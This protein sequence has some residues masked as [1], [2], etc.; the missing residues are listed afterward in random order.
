[1]H[2]SYRFQNDWFSSTIEEWTETL[3]EYRSTP[4]L[5]F[6]E[7]G[8]FEGRSAVWLLENILTNPTSVLTCI[9]T[10]QGSFE[11]H[12]TGLDFNKIEQNFDHN[13]QVSGQASQVK[14]IKGLSA[15]ELKRLQIYS[16]DFV[17]I[18]ASHKASNVLEDA[19]LSWQLLKVG[20]VII[21][22]DYVWEPQYAKI[23]S[24]Q[25][26]IDAFVTCYADKLKVLRK[27]MQMT[28][29]KVSS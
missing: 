28:I 2:P 12:S 5:S 18:D 24:P 13:I 9:D 16:Y 4:N 10:W 8:S 23:D 19:V 22:D 15:I 20:G 6:L 1:M 7:I 14:K 21:F 25:I 3:A 11:H 17:Y 29:Q 26:A 27:G